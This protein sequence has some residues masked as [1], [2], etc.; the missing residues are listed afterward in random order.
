MFLMGVGESV[1]GEVLRQLTPDE[2]R[3]ITSEISGTHTV[4]ADEMLSVFRE[5]ESLTLEGRLFVKGG[6]ECARR[7]V[8]S[9][10]GAESALKLLPAGETAAASPTE[11][12]SGALENADPRQLATFLKKEH[13]Q[14]IAV[15]LSTLPPESGSALLQSLPEE[16][17]GEVAVRMAS[18]DRVSPEAFQ[19]VTEAI[20]NK[21]SNIRKITKADGVKALA[22]VLN[23]VDA[24]RADAILAELDSQNRPVADSV[25]SLMFVFEDVLSINKEGMKALVGKLDRKIMTTALKGT[26]AKIRDHFTQCMSQRSADMLNEDMEALG[27]IRIRDVQAAQQLVIAAIRELQQSGTISLNRSGGGD[28]YVV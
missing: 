18:L 22:A 12:R 25:R 23:R 5:F 28:E 4:G 16:I 17:H 15:L 6:V 24:T 2:V 26:S 14:T 3:R 9:A 19:K 10:L 8:E 21:L 7:M 11:V 13:P 1:S 20:G 27:P